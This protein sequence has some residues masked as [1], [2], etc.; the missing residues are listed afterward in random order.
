MPLTNPTAI[1][2][3]ISNLS[4]VWCSTGQAI[5]QLAPQSPR[6]PYRPRATNARRQ[7][8]IAEVAPIDRSTDTQVPVAAR[9]MAKL[10]ELAGGGRAGPTS[11]RA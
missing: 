4:F 6:P 1:V 11:I 2:A 10:M 7:E 3:D 9:H 8:P 5:P